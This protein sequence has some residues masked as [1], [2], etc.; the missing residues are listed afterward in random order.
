MASHPAPY[1]SLTFW[2]MEGLV[3]LRATSK[4]ALLMTICAAGLLV[5]WDEE[6]DTSL[7][8]DDDMDISDEIYSFMAAIDASLTSAVKSAPLC[9]K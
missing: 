1:W 8:S 4:W 9:K 2:D 6:S 3:L 5:D 7:S